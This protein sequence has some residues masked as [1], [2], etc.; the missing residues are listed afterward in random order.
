MLPSVNSEYEYLR[1]LIEKGESQHLDFKFAITDSRKIARSLVAFANTDGGT[2]LIG[3]KDN[4][5]IAGIRSDEE[6]YMADAAASMYCKPEMKLK[7]RLWEPES[8]KQVLEVVVKP[9]GSKMWKALSEDGQWKAWIRYQDQNIVAGNVWELVWKK[10]HSS[11]SRSIL[12]E[13]REQLV[14]SHLNIGKIYSIEDIVLLTGIHTNE[15]EALV[16][17][18]IVLGLM[19]MHVSESGIYCSVK[20]KLNL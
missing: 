5:K 20:K 4:G 3:V 9:D 10:K 1:K 12:F 7:L 17:D 16:S 19:E 11:H 8:N 14:F 13:K 6:V 15:V 18:F 2:L